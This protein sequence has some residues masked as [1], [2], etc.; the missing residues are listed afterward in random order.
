VPKDVGYPSEQAK[1]LLTEII[2]SYS[3]LYKKGIIHRDLKPQNILT[4]K[5]GKIKISDFGT[6]SE[7]NDKREAKNIMTP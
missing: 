2:K 7:K 4:T 5:E 6:A 1:H 3:T